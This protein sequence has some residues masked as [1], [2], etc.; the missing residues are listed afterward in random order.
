VGIMPLVDGPFERGKC[1][2]KLVQ[3][4]AGGLPVVASPV[5]VNQQMVNPS[6][7]GYL[8]GSSEEWLDAFR[9]LG[10]D[11]ELRLKLGQ[12]GR[13]QAEQMYNLQVTAPR[14]LDLLSSVQRV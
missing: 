14:L 1:G 2:Y 4:M 11:T 13:Q 3:Y 5:G 7:N 10:I 9:K 6:R 12:S 8:A